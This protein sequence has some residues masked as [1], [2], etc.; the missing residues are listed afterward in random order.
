MGTQRLGIYEIVLAASFGDQRSKVARSAHVVV[1]RPRDVR[2]MVIKRQV[3]V[4]CHF[5]YM[6]VTSCLR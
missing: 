1:T 6:T 4:Q 5:E 2:D 3:V